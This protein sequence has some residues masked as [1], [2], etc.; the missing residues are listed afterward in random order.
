M[1]KD[2]T[3]N[4]DGDI[5]ASSETG[6]EVKENHEQVEEE[7]RL[8]NEIEILKG[9]LE[10]NQKEGKRLGTINENKKNLKVIILV[11]ISVFPMVFIVSKLFYFFYG[12]DP[13][14]NSALPWIKYESDAFITSIFIPLLGLVEFPVITF[15][16]KN[17]FKKKVIIE[18][19][20][21]EGTV[22][23]EA[24]EE[25]RR[26]KEEIEKSKTK[27]KITPDAKIHPINMQVFK[28]Q[29]KKMYNLHL[30]IIK[31]INKNY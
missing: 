5:L 16:C 6:L 26:K 1:Y 24:L 8:E 17:Y 15:L 27:E 10:N 31:V 19:N 12:S 3:F 7:L 2:F 28:D 29:L 11:L 13:L 20:E 9:E 23:K 21:L 22:L 14:F 25:K 4:I 30:L 18:G